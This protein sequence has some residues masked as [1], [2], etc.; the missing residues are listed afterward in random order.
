[1]S[2]A[3]SVSAR[4][5]SAWSEAPLSDRKYTSLPLPRP[6]RRDELQ[7]MLT[8]RSAFTFSAMW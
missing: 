2:A 4:S 8:N 5:W 1:M 6:R 7:W 3:F